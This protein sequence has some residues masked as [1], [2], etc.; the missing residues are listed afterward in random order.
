MYRFELFDHFNAITFHLTMNVAEF[1]ED[2][3]GTRLQFMNADGRENVSKICQKHFLV[4]N[5]NRL[6]GFIL[7]IIPLKVCDRS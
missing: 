5:L 1:R 2:L 7:I 6:F 3:A 4:N